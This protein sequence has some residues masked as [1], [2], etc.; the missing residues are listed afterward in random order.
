MAQAQTAQAQTAQAHSRD[1]GTDMGDE[2][3]DEDDRVAPRLPRIGEGGRRGDL[4]DRRTGMRGKMLDRPRLDLGR[5]RRAL[6]TRTRHANSSPS[7]ET[8]TALPGS[9]I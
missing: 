2:V 7:R 6:G 4:A 5:R 8:E 9:G 3:A 1:L